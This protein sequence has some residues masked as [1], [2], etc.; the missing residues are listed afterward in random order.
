MSTYEKDGVMASRW[1]RLVCIDGRTRRETRS[2]HVHHIGSYI[3]AGTLTP[4][5]VRTL[6]NS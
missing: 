5:K 3:Q 6:S 2:L 1:R 4:D